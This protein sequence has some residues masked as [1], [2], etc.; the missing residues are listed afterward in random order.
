MTLSLVNFV[1]LSNYR[2]LVQMDE[3]EPSKLSAYLSS[4]TYP[5]GFSKDEK[6]R[7]REKSKR[8]VME[9]GILIHI[10]LSGTSFRVIASNTERLH[11]ME[12]LHSDA[13]GGSHIGR[14]STINKISAQFWW[15]GMSN[16][17]REVFQMCE[18]ASSR[19]GTSA[20]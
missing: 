7:L 2:Q 13:V 16:D 14:T 1:L 8:F 19:T 15:P 20:Q 18:Y 5:V 11:I 3:G 9:D 6:R 12:Y 10:R 4:S 17:I